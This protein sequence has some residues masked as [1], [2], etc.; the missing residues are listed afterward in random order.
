MTVPLPA[1]IAEAKARAEKA[2]EPGNRA[3]V[4]ERTL[5][6]D[7]L[8]LADHLA[9][10]HAVIEAARTYFTAMDRPLDLAKNP[11]DWKHRHDEQDAERALRTALADF[12]RGEQG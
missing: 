6:A 7:V 2:L 9:R 3:W 5:A 8:F 10:A 1:W 4:S 12:D 11:K